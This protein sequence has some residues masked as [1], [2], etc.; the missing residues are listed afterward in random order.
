MYKCIVNGT[1]TWLQARCPKIVVWLPADV[2]LPFLKRVQM[3][4]GPTKP[5]IQ[6]LMGAFCLWVKEHGQE[7]DH[8]PPFCAEVKNKQ[9]YTPTPPHA[10]M[11]CTG[12][13]LPFT[14]KSSQIKSFQHSTHYRS[15]LWCNCRDTIIAEFVISS[16]FNF[17]STIMGAFSLLMQVFC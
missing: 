14:H 17:N 5:P 16:I 10:S 1:V 13:V 7:A 8:S 9:I 2:D 6:Q 4:S 15:C 12:T 11:A 3:G